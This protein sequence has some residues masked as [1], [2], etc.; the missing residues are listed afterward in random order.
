M[1]ISQKMNLLQA[2]SV[3]MMAGVVVFGLSKL[4]LIGSEINAI[5]KEDMPL[6]ESLTA[7]TVGQLEQNIAM[8]RALRAGKVP[9]HGGV[10]VVK[11]MHEAFEGLNTEIIEALDK[12][13]QLAGQ[14]LKL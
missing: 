4:E 7:I 6:I 8:E 14:G 11:K 12:G 9:D 13:E 5:A 10:S 1:K 3:L 2:V